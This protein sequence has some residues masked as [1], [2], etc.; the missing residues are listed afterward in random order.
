MTGDCRRTRKL[1]RP[2][3]ALALCGEP[4]E[5]EDLAAKTTKAQPADTIWNAVRLPEIQAVAA[6]DRNDAAGAID[7]MTAAAPYE[8]AY[9]DASYVRGMAYLKMRKGTE[10]A[11]EFEKVVQDLN[12]LLQATREELLQEPEKPV[13]IE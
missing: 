13:T 6:L 7:R 8:R 9:P 12:G 4:V 11:A 1:G 3:L 10:A 5:A 2:P